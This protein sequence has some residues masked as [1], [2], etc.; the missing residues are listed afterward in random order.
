MIQKNIYKWHRR[1]SIVIAIPVLMWTLSGMLHPVMSTFK[2]EVKNQFLPGHPID[3]SK[4]FLSLSEVLAMNGIETIENFRLITLEDNVYYQVL[5]DQK[6]IPVYIHAGDG[7]ILDDGD[8]KY[9]LA[10]SKNFLGDEKVPT[11]DVTL[12]REF[13]DEYPFINR[14][15]P[16]YKVTFDREDGL[17][18]FVETY[19]DRMAYAVNDLRHGFSRFFTTFHSWGGLKALGTFRYVVIVVL[20][21]LALFVAV[22]GI[23]IYCISNAVKVTEQSSAYIKTRKLHRVTSIVVSITT[24]MFAFSG[25]FHAFKKIKPDNRSA[26]LIQ[27][28]I[29]ARDLQW[30]SLSFFTK[31]KEHGKLKNI[32]VVR[33][34]T[35]LYWQTS[36]MDEQNKTKT[37]YLSIVSLAELTNGEE[38]YASFLANQYSGNKA[39]DIVSIEKITRFGGEYGFVNKRLPVMKVQY[40]NNGNE[41][42]YVEPS[43]GKLSVRI[44]DKDLYEGFSFAYLHK[45]HFADALGKFGRDI[46]TVLAAL[47]NFSVVIIGLLLY[48]RK[49]NRSKTENKKLKVEKLSEL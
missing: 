15:L 1:I 2:P 47:A 14:L 43:S 39:E 19:G 8:R 28:S 22:S 25:G 35:S 34:D 11:T 36:I 10:L 45:F 41:R 44:E 9:A 4:V 37:L 17:R 26:S 12:V 40:R 13:S 33:I 42:Y 18:I 5:H 20:C 31:I 30:D 24:L 23:Y 7:K 48:F 32:S 38:E 21:S 3:S 29:P 27:T 49:K 46:L 6:D 16:V